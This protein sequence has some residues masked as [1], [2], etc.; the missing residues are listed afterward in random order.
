MTQKCCPSCR[1]FMPVERLKL[2]TARDG[3]TRLIC[4]GCIERANTRPEVLS[5]LKKTKEARQ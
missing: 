2:K 3:R 4:L 5:D 1:R